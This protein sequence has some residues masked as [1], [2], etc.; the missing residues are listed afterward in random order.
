[1]KY[2]TFEEMTRSETA[3]RLGIDNVPSDETVRLNIEMLVA[4]I[5]DPLREW[6]DEPIIVSSGYRCEHLNKA[7]G[8]VHDSQHLK[9]QAVDIRPGRNCENY[10]KRLKEMFDWICDHVSFDQ[11]IYYPKRGFIHVSYASVKTNRN[12][13]YIRPE[14]F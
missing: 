12:M 9:G 6:F 2:F 1:M 5:L 11:V 7:V 3:T 10:S 14:H 13:I 8:G 4:C